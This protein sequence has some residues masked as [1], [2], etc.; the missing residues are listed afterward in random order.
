MS[1]GKNFTHSI[2]ICHVI[3]P[4][5][6]PSYPKNIG[7]V[8]PKPLKKTNKTSHWLNIAYGKLSPRDLL[9]AQQILVAAVFAE[10][11]RGLPHPPRT[12]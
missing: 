9:P 8:S 5:I 12:P 4:L 2:I 7:V 1:W 3:S 6:L 11:Q 10:R